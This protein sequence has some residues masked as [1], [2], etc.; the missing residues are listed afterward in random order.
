LFSEIE[1]H[2]KQCDEVV[3]LMLQLPEY[4]PLE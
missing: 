1:A 2:D 3:S 4:A